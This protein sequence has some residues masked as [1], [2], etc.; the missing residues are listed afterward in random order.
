MATIRSDSQHGD[1]GAA[2]AVDAEPLLREE[3]EKAAKRESHQGTKLRERSGK[4]T[5]APT[6]VKLSGPSTS[7]KVTGGV[8]SGETMDRLGSRFQIHSA[9]RAQA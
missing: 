1:Q 3:R 7:G 6:R 9:R 8:D 4:V 5:V 2:I